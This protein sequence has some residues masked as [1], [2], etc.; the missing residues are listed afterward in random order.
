M[1][2]EYYNEKFE[3]DL[4]DNSDSEPPKVVKNQIQMKTP[5]I[6]GLKFEE[7]AVSKMLKP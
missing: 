1:S 7:K 5:K 3:S 2:S 6:A 4:V